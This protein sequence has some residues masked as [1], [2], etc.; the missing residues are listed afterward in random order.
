[1]DTINIVIFVLLL[2]AVAVALALYAFPGIFDM[3]RRDTYIDLESG[4]NN[5]SDDLSAL[6]RRL[7]TKYEHAMD[8][9]YT[10]MSDEER[11]G[12][13]KKMRVDLEDDVMRV[14]ASGRGASPYMSAMP[15]SRGVCLDGYRHV[16][17]NGGE[18]CLKLSPGDAVEVSPD[19]V[20]MSVVSPDKVDPKKD[21]YKVEIGGV[22]YIVDKSHPDM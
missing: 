16:N 3:F 20:F 12:A 13:L 22:K 15:T 6:R 2:V 9:V 21:Y 18:M 4:M 1:M 17:F 5:P 7:T 10:P 11:D 8:H 14:A 19:F